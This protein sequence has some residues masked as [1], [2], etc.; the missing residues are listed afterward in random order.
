[1]MARDGFAVKDVPPEDLVIPE[2]PDVEKV[3]AVD[4][5][6]TVVSAGVGVAQGGDVSEDVPAEVDL[7]RLERA[8][9]QAE[10]ELVQ[11]EVKAC[12]EE[13]KM[14]EVERLRFEQEVRKIIDGNGSLHQGPSEGQ[15]AAP[16]GS[17]P[18]GEVEDQ[19]TK[20][21]DHNESPRGVGSSLSTVGKEEMDDQKSS[22]HPVKEEASG[23]GSL[24]QQAVPAGYNTA[25]PSLNRV[26]P[27]FLAAGSYPSTYYRGS[28]TP[29]QNAR[30]GPTADEM[31]SQRVDG[32]YEKLLARLDELEA[33]VQ[34]NS[35]R[36]ATASSGNVGKAVESALKSLKLQDSGSSTDED[37]SSSSE[38]SGDEALL[39]NYTKDT[40]SD[41]KVRSRSPPAQKL[42][43]FHGDASKWRS[44]I[45]SFKTAART[46]EWG[47]E[48][49]LNRL[50]SCMQDKAVDYICSRP[51]EIRSDYKLL[52]RDL[53]RRYGQRE[54]SDVVIRK[55]A[56]AKQHEEEDLD[57]FG[58]RIIRLTV[59]AYPGV[60]DAMVQKWA[61]SAFLRGCR[62]KV[63]A[64]LTRCSA[65]K[66]L[67]KAVRRMKRNSQEVGGQASKSRNV[68]PPPS[69]C[70]YCQ[71][72]GH[73]SW[74]CYKRAQDPVSP[75][76]GYI[77][78]SKCGEKG[79]L[80]PQCPGPGKLKTH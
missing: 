37:S 39:R 42:P 45:F 15:L 10:R 21:Y 40:K 8:Q 76:S 79:H 67:Q 68:S 71:K 28:F 3:E 13:R 47:K 77:V 51:K 72:T 46:Y 69:Y 61:A 34:K 78:C 33:K 9:L 27:V 25:P 12:A 41:R 5:G 44:F 54:P 57:Q 55:L 36:R 74:E 64:M 56:S 19:K 48:S 18:T 49:K 63:P 38:G 23:S 26:P 60:D 59:D 65:P 70:S 24:Q 1:M 11:N 52:L 31:F 53:K 58:E 50:L 43:I 17:G 29:F 30:P 4:G 73:H 20:G 75:V 7:L 80:Y 14:F 16:K 62:D 66:S 2:V 6:G 32:Q 22:P 35:N